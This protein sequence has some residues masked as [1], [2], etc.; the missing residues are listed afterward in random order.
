M[1]ADRDLRTRLSFSS[2]VGSKTRKILIGVAIGFAFGFACHGGIVLLVVD[3]HR[4]IFSKGVSDIDINTAFNPHFAMIFCRSRQ[5]PW[6]NTLTLFAFLWIY[7]YH[8]IAAKQDCIRLV[9]PTKL[10]KS[11][12]GH[13]V[14]TSPKVADFLSVIPYHDHAVFVS[15]F[16]PRPLV[17]Q[18]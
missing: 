11:T 14:P 9:G 13:K 8:Y 10:F 5:R 17:Y 15:F 3:R 12:R 7:P 4:D 6:V 18:L 2:L 16:L 1:Q